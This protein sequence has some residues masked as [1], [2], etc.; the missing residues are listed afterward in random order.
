MDSREKILATIKKNQP[1]LA[2]LPDLDSLL[3]SR[4]ES[5]ERFKTIL[6]SIGGTVIEVGNFDEIKN[7][8][9]RNFQ[10]K[11]IV[12]TIPD[13]KLPRRGSYAQTENF[14]RPPHHLASITLAVLPGKFAVA[15]N[16]AVWL[17]DSDMGDRAL[18]FITE[19]L[20]LVISEDTILPTLH[21]AYERIESSPY[22]LG[23]F[24][25]GPSK[26]ADIEQSLVLGAHGA[27]SLIVFLIRQK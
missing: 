1:Q 3:S 6:I 8:I 25:A 4:G 5:V 11:N 19:H 20:A 7:F 21:H 14:D 13:L 12:S 2:S 16:G 15:E 22:N 10:E 24:I 23:T 9:D 27:K 18:P 26:T 17:T